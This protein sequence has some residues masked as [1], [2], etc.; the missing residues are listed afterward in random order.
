[1]G[2]QPRSAAGLLRLRLRLFMHLCYPHFVPRPAIRRPLAMLSMVFVLSIVA[3]GVYLVV[4]LTLLPEWQTNP[5]PTALWL[6]LFMWSISCTVVSYLLTALAHPGRIP[7]S[8][9]P[10]VWQG[11]DPA[12][13]GVPLPL[14]ATTT[15]GEAGPASEVSIVAPTKANLYPVAPPAVHAAGTAMLRADGRHRFCAHCNVFKPDRTHHCST[16]RECVLQMDHHCPFTGN[17]CVGFLNRKFFV[18]FLYYATLSCSLVAS[19]TPRT[20]L[21][22]LVDLEAR[23]TTAALAWVIMLMMGYVL[24]ALHAL[25]LIPF[26]AF[27]TY[28]ILKNR[29]TIEN[30]EARPAMHA[31]VLR[32]SDRGWLNN[33][34][35]VFGPRPLLWFIPVAFGRE[36]DVIEWAPRPADELV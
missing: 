36:T 14:N 12:N 3:T 19:L 31:D 16:C 13:P 34:K 24:C 22:C 30:Q 10:I 18:L 21:T 17:S 25:A 2:H 20:I 7:E 35:G 5:L 9:R 23:P 1:M 32:R 6:A 26:S 29:T 11:E 15:S 27:H 28:L 4:P 33:W 8:W